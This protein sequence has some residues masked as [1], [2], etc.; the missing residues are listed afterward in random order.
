[1]YSTESEKKAYRQGYLKGRKDL[2]S[3]MNKPF[4]FDVIDSPFWY[5]VMSYGRDK[6]EAKNK[7]LDFCRKQSWFPDDVEISNFSGKYKVED[8]VR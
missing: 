3:E 8:V 2:F 7:A 5:S 6:D 4:K 1:M